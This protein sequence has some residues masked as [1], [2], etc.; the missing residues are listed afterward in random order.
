MTLTLVITSFYFFPFEFKFLPGANTK[1]ILAGIG[2]VL[3]GLN[4]ARYGLGKMDRDLFHLSL[5][6]AIVSLIGFISA[7]VMKRS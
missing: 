3:L 1:M 4:L 7:V 5:W 2:L 6:A